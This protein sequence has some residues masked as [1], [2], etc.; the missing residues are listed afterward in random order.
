MKRPPNLLIIRDCYSQARS[1]RRVLS[2]LQDDLGD[3]AAM[4]DDPELEAMADLIEQ[5]DRQLEKMKD[6]LA[7]ISH[8]A[9]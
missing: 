6:R 5:I 8:G 7:A 1:A 3:M 2:M 4:T 9:E